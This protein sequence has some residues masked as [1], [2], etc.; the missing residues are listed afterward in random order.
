[1]K[2][3]NTQIDINNSVF[4]TQNNTIDATLEAKIKETKFNVNINGNTSNPKI[5]FDTKDLLKNEIDKQLEK[6]QGKIEE[7]INKALGGKLEDGKAKE[8]INNLKSF[9]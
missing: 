4:D 6:N 5:S 1:M 8:L 3:A 7:K 2:S 9:F